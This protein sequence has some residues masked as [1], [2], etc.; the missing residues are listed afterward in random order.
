MKILFLKLLFFATCT[1]VVYAGGG[2]HPS[3]KYNLLKND[4]LDSSISSYS[5]NGLSDSTSSYESEKEVA[6]DYY[7]KGRDSEEVNIIVLDA[8]GVRTAGSLIILETLLN[9]S[10]K[11]FQGVFDLAGGASMGGVLV[12]NL[13]VNKSL[14]LP[15]EQLL[16]TWEAFHKLSMEM[17]G[18]KSWVQKQGQSLRMHFKGYRQSRERLDDL[19]TRLFGD[20]SLQNMDL[21]VVITAVAPMLHGQVEQVIFSSHG[22]VYSPMHK[23]YYLR[24]ICSAALSKL[25]FFP[26]KH[27]RPCLDTEQGLTTAMFDSSILGGNITDIVL[28]EAKK[29]YPHK[30]INLFSIGTG[31]I[32]HKPTSPR[33][34]VSDFELSTSAMHMVQNTFTDKVHASMQHKSSN[35]KN[36]NYLRFNFPV[37]EQYFAEDDI[38]NIPHVI[39]A[40]KAFLEGDE[41]HWLRGEGVKILKKS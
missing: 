40:A 35:D 39:S 27:I 28:E 34:K 9:Q 4:S 7:L 29:L 41:G 13:S 8:G 3:S 10:N 23:D 14:G 15:Q 5:S 30:K 22:A 38:Q 12:A 32:D 37:P 33:K 31:Y 19:N 18:K 36:L 6:Q 16:E 1:W 11:S 26:A 21:P 2:Y 25:S 17:Y 20:T 24:D